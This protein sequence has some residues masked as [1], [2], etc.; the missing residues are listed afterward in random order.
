MVGVRWNPCHGI[1]VAWKD[2]SVMHECPRPVRCIRAHLRSMSS[3]AILIAITGISASAVETPASKV[4]GAGS[5]SIELP[6]ARAKADESNPQSFGEVEQLIRQLGSDSYAERE[7]AAEQL[8]L[9][10][11]DAIDALA[12]AATSEQSEV[13]W[14]ATGLLE[15][16]ALDGDESTLIAVAAKLQQLSD[17]G[18]TDLVRRSNSLRQVWKRNRAERAISALQAVGAQVHSS[19]YY[20]QMGGPIF[21]GGGEFAGPVF[22]GDII[23]FEEE[24]AIVDIDIVEGDVL[25][26]ADIPEGG[27]PIEADEAPVSD[28]YPP[29]D[30]DAQD[31]ADADHGSAQL[32]EVDEQL[33]VPHEWIQIETEE[34]PVPTADSESVADAETIL[35]AASMIEQHRRQTKR[36]LASAYR[37]V[38]ADFR[39]LKLIAT[40]G[41]EQAR[42]ATP[43]SDGEIAQPIEFPNIDDLQ[44]DMPVEAIA[45]EAIFMPEGGRLVLGG[46]FAMPVAQTNNNNTQISR[47][48]VLNSD[49]SGD[50]KSLQLLQEIDNIYSMQ[51]TNFEVT[52]ETLVE[53]AMLE[54][55]T[56]LTITDSEFDTAAMTALRRIRPN[57]QITTGGKAYLGVNA[58]L[59]NDG[60]YSGCKITNV[61]DGSA[62]SKAGLQ[63]GDIIVRVD[64]HPVVDFPTLTFSVANR[65]I[66][67]RVEVE[68]LRGGQPVITVAKLGDRALQGR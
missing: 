41:N 44:L 6:V 50:L 35:T 27:L 40:E 61:V 28:E 53:I 52:A 2:L 25:E 54:T 8:K 63:I 32:A 39:P 43:I 59:T 38:R 48:V 49:W 51:L 13:A 4:L 34:P 66:G 31:I 16:I 22:G 26:I 21:V 30:D 68:V 12:N 36:E 14:R 3:A 20:G 47:T 33:A 46:G 64:Q 11:V 18:R 42:S 5:S 15:Q 45:A 19:A 57:L 65:E 55:L 29:T 9:C 56:S 60:S 17:S 24:E 23:F 67:E 62:A 7:N 58:E 37:D 1:N 10:G